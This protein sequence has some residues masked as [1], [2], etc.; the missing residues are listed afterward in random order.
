MINNKNI[1]DIYKLTP[2]QEGIYFHS[3]YEASSAY[4]EQ[5]AYRVTG[6]LDIALV[7]QSLNELLKYHDV[8]RTVF[9]HEKVGRVLQIVLKECTASFYYEDLQRLAPG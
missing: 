7:E 3:L 4:F 2:L 5:I 1:Q 8:L 6:D 9:N